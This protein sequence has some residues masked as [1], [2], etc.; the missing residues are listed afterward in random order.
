MTPGGALVPFYFP[1]GVL[2][3]KK[4][5]PALFLKKSS[6]PCHFEILEEAL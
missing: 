3:L 1:G 2:P 6:Y 5:I 4:K